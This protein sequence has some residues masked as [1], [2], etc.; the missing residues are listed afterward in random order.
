MVMAPMV[1]RLVGYDSGN[2]RA[3]GAILSNRTGSACCQFLEDLA[4]KATET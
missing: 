3:L 2:V 4:E 1:G